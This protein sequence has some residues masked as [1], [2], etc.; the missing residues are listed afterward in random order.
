MSDYNKYK[1]DEGKT[2]WDLIPEVCFREIMKDESEYF[3]AC[4]FL[5]ICDDIDFC[6]NQVFNEIRRILEHGAIKYSEESWRILPSPQQRYF[7]AFMRHLV[8]EDGEQFE[9]GHIDEDSGML[10]VFHCLC[11]CLFLLWFEI[12]EKK[13]D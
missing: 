12:E 8:M 5:K 11:N 13:N 4:T 6:M 1:F 7:A 9:K 10:T 2:R 3:W